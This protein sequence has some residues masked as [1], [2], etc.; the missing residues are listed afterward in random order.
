MSSKVLKCCDRP[1]NR[2][3]GKQGLEQY[4][5]VMGV[6][7][8]WP[9]VG[10]AEELATIQGAMGGSE[11]SGIVISGAAGV[12]KTRLA[13]EVLDRAQARGLAVRWAVATQAASAIPFGALAQL[14]P[15]LGERAAGQTQL[16]RWAAAALQEAAAARRLILGIDDAHLL[17]HSSAAL[18]HQLAATSTAFVMVTIRSGEPVLDAILGL[19][20]DGLAERLELQPLS[21]GEVE[22]LV[23]AVLGGQVDGLTLHRL[24]TATQGNSLLLRELV[25]AGLEL[26]NLERRDDIWRWSGSLG[27]TSRLADLIEARLVRLDGPQRAVLEL[28]AVSE[29]L[30]LQILDEHA[31]P[32]AL[33]K[34]ERQSL[35]IVEQDGRRLDAR[36]AHPLYGE[37][38]RRR[39]PALRARTMCRQLAEVVE[40]LGMRRRE[41]LL[42]VATWHLDSADSARPDLLTAAAGRAVT[43]DD[44]LAERLARAAVVAGGGFEA[45]MAL[46]RALHGQRRFQE[47]EEVLA[48]L[49]NLAATDQQR[50]D[51]A[52][53]R[54]DT[55]RVSHH[56]T[57][58]TSVLQA[59]AAAVADPSLR[60]R[61]APALAKSL[62]FDG[63]IGEALEVASAV[64]IHEPSDE[65]AFAQAI[66]IAS[67]ALVLAGRASDALAV[68]DL[69]G[70]LGDQWKAEAPW[71]HEMVEGIRV[72][73]CLSL[74][75]FDDA[76]AIAE[77]S[78]RQALGDQWAWGVTFWAYE[79][80]IVTFAR[81]RVRTVVRWG[82]ERLAQ[83]PNVGNVTL[84][85]LQLVLPLAVAGDLDGAEAAFRRAD[86][87][88]ISRS[89]L[90]LLFVEEARRW[91]EAGRGSLSTAVQLA[92]RAADLAKSIGANDTYAVALH[93][94][95]R[96]GGSAQVASRLRGLAGVIHGPVVPLYA[97]HAMALTAQDGTALDEVAA[98]FEA[99][100]GML[101]AAE[102]ATEA[103]VAHRA[104]GHKQAARA[105]A[106]RASTLVGQCEGARTPALRLLEQPPLLT[107][108]EREIASLV[109]AGFSNRAIA[110]RLILSVRT[111]DNHLQHVFDKLG[112]RRRNELERLI[113]GRDERNTAGE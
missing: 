8:A 33:E 98:S 112:I 38:L 101:L 18:V 97:A 62:V 52:I 23:G 69:R 7:G 73:A 31:A 17:D 113:G 68:I 108:R 70:R 3:L 87:E 75:R 48:G 91:I 11:A 58:A 105:S 56:Y 86:P 16:L 43:G 92:L 78:Y 22:R 39:T 40:N 74:G 95:A 66:W 36:L 55:L 12:G 103:A 72:A 51:L 64:L 57:A 88:G 61:L 15:D 13:R 104:A 47:A 6:K 42:R 27:V 100:G 44:G 83:V 9:L 32:G 102:A 2:T 90:G 10:R 110:E 19:W 99:I 21:H 67:W 5:P 107:P 93:D 109:A 77:A 96:L 76:E 4:D 26:G 65:P 29:P 46:G 94:A 30:G 37:V 71:T 54:S 14:L 1:S 50:A 35:V 89:R 85:E 84:L 59:A 81:G 106:A 45:G 34:L 49:A 82:Q 53:Q 41:D 20:K 24:S 80:M 28:L 111:V 60:D 79:L 25:L 63:R